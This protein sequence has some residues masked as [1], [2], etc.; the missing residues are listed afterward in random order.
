METAEI[1]SFAFSPDGEILAGSGWNETR[2]WDVA[3]GQ[4]KQTLNVGT[5]DSIT[6]SLDGQVLGIG[7][8][9]WDTS[10]GQHLKRLDRNIRGRW[11]GSLTYD[12][13]P[14]SRRYAGTW[15]D[16]F[17]CGT[18]PQEHCCGVKSI[19]T[20]PIVLPSV[21]MVRH[22]PVGVAIIH[23]FVGCR[24]RTDSEHSH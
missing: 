13:S 22:L 20:V 21:R 9:L 17:S 2:L 24:H 3:T 10:T 4:H 8:N 18:Y 23:S 5:R 15:T 7:D 11:S 14:D 12:F 16:S 1:G 19:R 6:F